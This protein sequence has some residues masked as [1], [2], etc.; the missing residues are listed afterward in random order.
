M[1]E[2]TRTT[3]GPYKAFSRGINGIPYELVTIP[4]SKV[5]GSVLVVTLT[6]NYAVLFPNLID[7]INWATV[8]ISVDGA[9]AGYFN[10]LKI[11]QVRMLSGALKMFL[12]Y[13]Q[14]YDAIRILGRNVTGGVQSNGFSPS[15]E[16]MA[17]FDVSV[18]IQPHGGFNLPGNR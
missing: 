1:S 6:D 11:Q 16:A 13:D 8:E 12:P 9:T 10:R 5:K 7:T 15:L 4:Y 3:Y 14:P 2:A 17:I 18:F